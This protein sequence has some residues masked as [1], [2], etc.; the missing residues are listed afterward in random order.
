METYLTLVANRTN[1]V[2]KILTAVGTVVLPINMLTGLYGTNLEALPGARNPY[3]FWV[4][5]GVGLLTA[6]G[7]VLL[8]RTR[9]WC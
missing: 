3:G 4:F 2:M 8:L 5:C 1:D 7:A 6:T 9:K